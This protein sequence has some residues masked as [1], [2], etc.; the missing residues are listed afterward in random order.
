MP[1]SINY[2]AGGNIG[3]SCFVMANDPIDYQVITANGNQ[4]ILGISQMG[5]N[6]FP[7][8]TSSTLIAAASGQILAV[9]ADADH[10]EPLLYLGASVTGG[11]LLCSDAA[12]HGIPFVPGSSVA[13]YVGAEARQSGASGALIKVRPRFNTVG[14]M[15]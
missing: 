6:H 5:A 4:P 10:D 9:F 12:G 1:G 14:R 3:V 11:Q 8:G 13:Q 15:T 2:Q 7:D